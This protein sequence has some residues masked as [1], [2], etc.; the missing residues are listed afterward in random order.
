MLVQKGNTTGRRILHGLRLRDMLVTTMVATT[1]VLA[2]IHQHDR[3]FAGSATK[4]VQVAARVVAHSHMTVLYQVSK[5]RIT[6]ADIKRG[7][8]DVGSASRFSVHS[9][10]PQGYILIFRVAAMPFKSVHVKGNGTDAYL[11]GGQSFVRRPY[12]RGTEAV[13]FSFQLILLEDVQPG[14]YAW[15]VDIGIIDDRGA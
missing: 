2:C 1:L 14:V 4:K 8:V 13:E 3:V 10:D 5:V 12:F 15:P 11:D 9:N 7:Y 6:R